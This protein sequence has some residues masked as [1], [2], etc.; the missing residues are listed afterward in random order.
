MPDFPIPTWTANT[1]DNTVN[2]T[3]FLPDPCYYKSQELYK[4]NFS[5][6]TAIMSSRLAQVSGHVSNTHGRGLLA[7]EVAIITG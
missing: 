7:E 2:N 5:L 3:R 1:R 4:S 6:F